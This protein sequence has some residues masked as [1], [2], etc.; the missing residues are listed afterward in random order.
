MA[1]K[2]NR[3]RTRKTKRRKY[4]GG[5]LT[6]LEQD[7]LREEYHGKSSPTFMELK[8]FV[9][10]KNINIIGRM[11]EIIT[12]VISLTGPL[13]SAPPP[14]APPPSA[15]PPSS[16]PDTSNWTFLQDNGRN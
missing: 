14:S 4:R 2:Y 10:E 7:M 3:R 6:T 13:S 15:P 11:H 12:F 16:Q 1:T 9:K 5:E 8:N